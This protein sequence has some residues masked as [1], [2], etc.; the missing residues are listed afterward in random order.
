MYKLLAPLPRARRE[1][2]P[3]QYGCHVG[4][5]A[6]AKTC[7]KHLLPHPECWVFVDWCLTCRMMQIM[8]RC[9][10]HDQTLAASF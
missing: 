6:G 10:R 2:W 9:A 4:L 5:Q 8:P 3:M 1:R 7:T